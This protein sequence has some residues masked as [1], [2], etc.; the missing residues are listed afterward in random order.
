MKF[1]ALILVL[2]FSIFGCS[3]SKEMQIGEEKTI[4]ASTSSK[5][6]WLMKTS[7]FTDGD[8][9]VTGVMTKAYDMSFGMNQANADGMQK[10]VNTMGN[11]VKT[12]TTQA[13]Q[14]ANM[15]DGDVG[16]YSSFAIAWVS[17][18]K[19]IMGVTSPESY[20]EKVEKNEPSGLTYSYN[21]Y[22]RLKI[23]K[24]DY[25][26]SLYGAYDE[27][28]KQAQK[29]NNQKAEKVADDLLKELK[30]QSK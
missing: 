10:L 30:D 22:T 16:R 6:D 13:L 8:L 28:K 7:E 23:S 12:Q 11:E 2:A 27:M 17:D 9:Y 24:K 18:T 25:Q 19:R 4:N 1:I 29:E 14:G 5:P 15:S 21:C 20:W 3:G 26:A